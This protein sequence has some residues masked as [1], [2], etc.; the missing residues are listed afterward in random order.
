M[1]HLGLQR[2]VLNLST[3]GTT[4]H[5]GSKVLVVFRPAEWSK[6]STSVAIRSIGETGSGKTHLAQLIHE[7]SQRA[8][9]PFLTVACGALPGELIESEL[10][11]HVKGSFT[12]AHADKDGKFLAAAEARFCWMK[13]TF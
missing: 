13:L 4:G 6:L 7:S 8:S 12:S 10:F 11:G 1:Q 2:L 3:G 9:D 5:G